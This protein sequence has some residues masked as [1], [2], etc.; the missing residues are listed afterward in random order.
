MGYLRRSRKAN[1]EITIAVIHSYNSVT[2]SRLAYG[3]ES[4]PHQA[5][6][7][8]EEGRLNSSARLPTHER[9]LRKIEMVLVKICGLRPLRPNSEHDSSSVEM[10]LSWD[11]NISDIFH[12]LLKG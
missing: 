4:S 3:G 6:T 7:A 5:R 11:T 12:S 2:P 8:A 9:S 1:I 10:E